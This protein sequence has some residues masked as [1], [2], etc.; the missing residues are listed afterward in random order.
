MARVLVLG[1]LLLVAAV[2]APVATTA[3]AAAAEPRAAGID[4]MAGPALAGSSLLFAEDAGTRYA[5]RLSAPG[6]PARTVAGGELSSGQ[7]GSPGDYSRTAI[8]VAASPGQAAYTE[9]WAHG[10]ARYDTGT[11]GTSAFTGPLSG[12][13]ARLTTCSAGTYAPFSGAVAVDASAVAYTACDGA[14]V[15][16]DFAPGAPVPLRTIAQPPGAGVSD[17]ALA[18]RYVAYTR[19]RVGPGSG[20]A[21]RTIVVDRVTGSEAYSLPAEE[22][23]D[24][25][26]DGLLAVTKFSGGV[27][28]ATGRLFWYSVSQPFPH[29][30]AQ[31]PCL[32]GVRVR[33]GAIAAVVDAGRGQRALALVDL[34]G[35]RRDVAALGPQGVQRGDV[36]FDG[37][38][39]SYALG[40]CDGRSDLFAVDV[41]S[42][43]SSEPIPTSCP[44]RL[45]SRRLRL[46][47]RRAGV[48]VSLACPRGCTGSA[49][50]E[51]RVRRGRRTRR[52]TLGSSRQFRISGVRCRTTVRLAITRKGRRLLRDRPRLRAQLELS[53]TDRAGRDV[54]KRVGVVVSSGRRGSKRSAA[55]G[56]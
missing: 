26:P 47:G 38:R 31:N 27:S 55:R 14:L 56:C 45:R 41:A 24:I 40:N 23:Y 7:E 22:D 35:R 18:G 20:G 16:Q 15:I 36:D 2:L 10:N 39:L 9:T 17:V 53:T 51:R 52:L 43:L 54:T 29:P 19:F 49:R 25:G 33:A 30:I 1:R 50:L 12:P 44:V 37:S 11:S 34:A 42:D 5:V 46:G 28:C 32:P 21:V 3:V 13:L 8:E 6:Q 4:L 48:I